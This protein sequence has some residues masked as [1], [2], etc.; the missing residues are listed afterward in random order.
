[1]LLDLT[2]LDSTLALMSSDAGEEAGTGWK[3]RTIAGY[4][5]AEDE[6]HVSE[7]RELCRSLP[8]KERK[9]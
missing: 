4:R 7:A 3:Q 1:M 5:G 2:S 6:G 9:S 8:Q